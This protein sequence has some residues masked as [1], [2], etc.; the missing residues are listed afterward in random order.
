[1]NFNTKPWGST[2]FRASRVFLE[3][4]IFFAIAIFIYRSNMIRGVGH[5][6]PR[7]VGQVHRIKLRS[8]SGT[9]TLCCRKSPSLSRNPLAGSCTKKNCDPVFDQLSD[10]RESK[11]FQCMATSPDYYDSELTRGTKKEC[12]KPTWNIVVSFYRNLLII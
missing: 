4:H 10:I 7:S 11:G 5:V 9:V 12:L 1:M 8:S 3:A 6:I 2:V